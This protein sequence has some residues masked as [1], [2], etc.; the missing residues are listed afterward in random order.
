MQKYKFIIKKFLCIKHI[1]IQTTNH[2]RD[3][4]NKLVGD[5]TTRVIFNIYIKMKHQLHMSR[6]A[7]SMLKYHSENGCVNEYIL[8][9]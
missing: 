2:T 7:N 8:R 3:F 6:L 4:L 9:E 1:H 5:D